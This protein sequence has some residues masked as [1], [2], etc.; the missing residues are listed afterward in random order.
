MIAKG[1]IQQ[2]TDK[3][4]RDFRGDNLFLKWIAVLAVRQPMRGVEDDKFHIHISAFVVC[5]GF[6]FIDE[7]PHSPG[8]QAER[9]Q[10]NRTCKKTGQKLQIQLKCAARNPVRISAAALK[11]LHFRFYM[12]LSII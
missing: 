1:C 7:V 10:D 3:L 11:Y 12:D 8:I 9:R 4:K 6:P 2:L 5:A